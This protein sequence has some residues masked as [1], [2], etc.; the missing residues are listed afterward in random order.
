MISRRPLLRCLR[1]PRPPIAAMLGACLMCVLFLAE[2]H[3]VRGQGRN[4]TADASLFRA[5]TTLNLNDF[6]HTGGTVNQ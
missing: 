4:R 3:S 5:D 6:D 1:Q 2:P